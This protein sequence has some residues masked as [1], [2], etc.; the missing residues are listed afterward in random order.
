MPFSLAGPPQ[1]TRNSWAV[2]STDSLS[3]DRKPASFGL[4]QSSPR[5]LRTPD[6]SLYRGFPFLVDYQTFSAE[7][8][9]PFPPPSETWEVLLRERSAE[10]KRTP[11]CPDRRILVPFSPNLFP[12]YWQTLIERFEDRRLPTT[13]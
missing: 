8:S 13:L 6:N 7:R 12:F 2:L 5:S 10:W 4:L 9:R 11:A 1:P 3:K